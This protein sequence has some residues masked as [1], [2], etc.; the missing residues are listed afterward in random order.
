M[1]VL[2]CNFVGEVAQISSLIV[3]FLLTQPLSARCQL[4]L[5]LG[6]GSWV[7]FLEV[8]PLQNQKLEAAQHYR[9]TK[10]S[11]VNKQP[12]QGSV[13]VLACASSS[14]HGRRSSK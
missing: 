6:A 4:A 2:S 13:P 5:F 8:A 10:N 1:K 7:P 3:G 14:N 9:N 12:P 11:S